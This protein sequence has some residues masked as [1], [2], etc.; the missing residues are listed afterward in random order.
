MDAYRIISSAQ[1]LLFLARVEIFLDW[2]LYDLIDFHTS[3]WKRPMK[4]QESYLGA[5]NSSYQLQT[6]ICDHNDRHFAR[7]KRY[8]VCVD[9]QTRQPRAVKE[10]ILPEKYIHIVANKSAVTNQFLLPTSGVFKHSF[11]VNFSDLDGNQHMNMAVYLRMC[12]DSAVIASKTG[13]LEHFT[14]EL[15]SYRLR[16][17][18]VRYIRECMVGD[19][20]LVMGWED[21]SQL[22]TMLFVVYMNDIVITECAFRFYLNPPSRL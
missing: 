8:I 2:S 3:L 6:S 12:M 7:V 16:Y 11:I 18:N 4:I 20:L 13:K 21:K 22:D 1:V 5:G 17:V 9:I 15:N 14:G 19:T 10:T